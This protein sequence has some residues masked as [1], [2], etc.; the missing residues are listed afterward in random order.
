MEE[1]WKAIL[2]YP[3]YEVSNLG[4]VRRNKNT[5]KY[6]KDKD[7]YKKIILCKQGKTKTERIHRLVAKTFLSN[8]DNKPQVDHID[9]NVENNI[10]CNL[11]WVTQSE[12]MMNTRRTK[13][14]LTKS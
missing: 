7:G 12:N 8:P 6:S 4:N 5:L 3:D 13:T 1:E 2:D 9:R 10:S 14:C 11:R